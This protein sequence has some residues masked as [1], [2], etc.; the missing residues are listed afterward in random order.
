VRQRH[1]L[2]LALVSSLFGCQGQSSEQQCSGAQLNLEE[3]VLSAIDYSRLEVPPFRNSDREEAVTQYFAELCPEFQLQKI[4]YHNGHNVIC[5]IPGAS[6]KRIIV[7]AHYDRIGTGR[8]VADNWSGIVLVSRLISELNSLDLN[9]TWEIVAFGAEEVELRGSKTYIREAGRVEELSD[10]LA[11]INVDTLGLGTVKID[12][13]SHENLTCQIENLADELGIELETV[14][15]PTITGDW[16]PFRR[17]NIPVLSMHSLDRQSLQ[18]V[19][20][21]KDS[22]QAI[23]EERLEDA[24]LLLLNLQRNFDQ[25]VIRASN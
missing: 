19:H 17:K 8:G 23:S 18:V 20:S 11:M 4:N 16:E 21:R 22:R 12:N 13:R 10:I 3:S 9:F 24:W 1:I 14:S 2:L 25:L 5:R 7:G 6:Q 15:L